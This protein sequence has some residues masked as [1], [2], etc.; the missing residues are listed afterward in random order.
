MKLYEANHPYYCSEGNY[1][2]NDCHTTWETWDDFIEVWGGVD[3]D[4]NLI[5]RWDWHEGE[6]YELKE[7]ECILRVHMVLQRKASLIS[8]DISVRRDEE[9]VIR[10]FLESYWEIMKKMWS[11]FE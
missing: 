9:F 1:Y 7:G 2:N 5:W 6:D 4:Y 3:K 8:H 11:P 10:E